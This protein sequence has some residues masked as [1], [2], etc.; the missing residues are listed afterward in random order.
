MPARQACGAAETCSPCSVPIGREG[1][2]TGSGK[3]RV[4][5]MAARLAG[6]AA[7]ICVSVAPRRDRVTGM[8]ARL[9]GGRQSSVYPRSGDQHGRA[10]EGSDQHGRVA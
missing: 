8:A 7:V 10:D 5:S 4:T 3:H 6:A 1:G 9:V 2:K